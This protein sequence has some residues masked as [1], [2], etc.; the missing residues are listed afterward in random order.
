[1][2]VV[3]YHAPEELDRCLTPLAREF[4]VTVVDNS[5]S[6]AVRTVA[7][8]HGVEYLDAGTNLGFGAGV[9]VALRKLR[10]GPPQDVLLLNPDAVLAR[11]DLQVLAQYLHQ[12][13]NARVA[14]VSPGLRGIDGA[15]Q[16]VVWPFPSPTRA[17]A[18]AVGLGRLPSQCS[19]VIGAVLLLRWDALLE[20]G[21]F[22]ERFFLYAEE[23]DWQR[24]ACAL[25]WKSA[26]CSSV[27]AEH[28]GAGTSESAFRREVLFHAAQETYVRKWHGPAGWW[29]YRCAMCTGAVA[30]T[31]VLGGERRSE[32]GRRAK[33]YVRGP[34][35]C[36]LLARE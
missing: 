29:A 24:R 12:P 13:D 4:D 23:T 35:R 36:A 19:F 27:V 18:E 11:C 1:V 6:T 16:R 32:A 17:W 26:V 9:N 22:D 28:R 14:A 3:A 5:S 34:R 21:L 30:R 20:V 7:L 15:E 33:I 25:G 8:A 10:T 2:V 31:L